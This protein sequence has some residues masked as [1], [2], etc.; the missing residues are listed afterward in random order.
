[1]DYF[2]RARQQTTVFRQAVF[3]NYGCI[4]DQI[5]ANDAETVL[6]GWR[7]GNVKMGKLRADTTSDT[8]DGPKTSQMPFLR[9]LPQ[10]GLGI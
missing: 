1:M 10:S 3:T 4:V 5:W 6:D 2:S 9:A 7:P 8:T